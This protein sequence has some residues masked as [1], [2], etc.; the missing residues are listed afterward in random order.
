[1]GPQI[2]TRVREALGHK[3]PAII[4]TGYISTEVMR[5]IT[6]QNCVQRTKPASAD[7]LLHLIQSLLAEPKVTAVQAGQLRDPNYNRGTARPAIFVVDDDSAVR[8]GMR[9]LF[10]DDERWS[11]ETYPNGEMFLEALRSHRDGVLIV[12]SQMPGMSGV[13]LLEKLDIEG[14]PLPAIMVTGHADV[15]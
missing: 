14:G 8:E 15:R 13:E 5:E 6:K 4:L 12:D 10:R 11:V 9:E 2:A 7:E 3:V 1:T